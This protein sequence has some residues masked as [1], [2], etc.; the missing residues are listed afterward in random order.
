M[1]CNPDVVGGG[2]HRVTGCTFKKRTLVAYDVDESSGQLVV[3]VLGVFHGG[4]DWEAALGG[5]QTDRRWV[6]EAFVRG[7]YVAGQS[8][9]TDANNDRQQPLS[10]PCF[11]T[12]TDAAHSRR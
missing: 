3:N 4:Q 10:V 7:E 1:N 5:D 2:R 9:A 12:T 11:P 6:D 8:S